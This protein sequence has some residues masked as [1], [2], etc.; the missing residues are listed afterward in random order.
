MLGCCGPIARTH[1]TRWRT[2]GLLQQRRIARPHRF[3]APQRPQRGRWIQCDGNAG[4]WLCRMASQ[5][6]GRCNGPMG[7]GPTARHPDHLACKRHLGI[8]RCVGSGSSNGH[9][10]VL[11][12][13]RTTGRGRNLEKPPTGRAHLFL[14]RRRNPQKAG[15]LPRRR[16][17]RDLERMVPKRKETDRRAVSC[18]RNTQH[19]LL[20]V[21]R[22]TND[23]PKARK[24]D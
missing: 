18:R 2:N 10:A 9:G 24:N 6:K 17:P 13:Q 14:V 3:L 8:T 5:W 4:G 23:L 15:Q 11:A 21:D 12:R 16:R 19:A 7:R 22:K 20:G 1:R